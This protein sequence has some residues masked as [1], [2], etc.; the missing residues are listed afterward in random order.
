M[1]FKIQH[2][3]SAV[4]ESTLM[5]LLE[6]FFQLV[7]A[8]KQHAI[9]DLVHNKVLR[10]VPGLAHSALI[11]K[12]MDLSGEAKLHKD[13]RKALHDTVLFLRGELEKTLHPLLGR[14]SRPLNDETEWEKRKKRKV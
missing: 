2:E 12:L 4:S 6:P 10:E 7:V 9:V 3:Q 8:G 5:L 1:G 11:S 13:R 14:R